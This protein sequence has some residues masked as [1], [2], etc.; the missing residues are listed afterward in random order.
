MVSAMPPKGTTQAVRLPRYWPVWPLSHRSSR[1]PAQ[2][3]STR[4]RRVRRLRS[5]SGH[6]PEEQRTDQDEREGGQRDPEREAGAKRGRVQHGELEVEHGAEE[7]ERELG[8]AWERGEG[9]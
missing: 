8:G 1:Q 5:T 9:D 4:R 6:R 2:A 7:E 3:A